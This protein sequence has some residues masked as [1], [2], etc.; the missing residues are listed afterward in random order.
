MARKQNNRFTCGDQCS[1]EDYLDHLAL[2]R[3]CGTVSILVLLMLS[4]FQYLYISYSPLGVLST[5]FLSFRD[6]LHACILSC[7]REETPPEIDINLHSLITT[8]SDHSPYFTLYISCMG[9]FIPLYYHRT[10]H[11]FYS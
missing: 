9:V 6:Y 4:V 11:F 5:H 10:W 2:H 3:L 7:R 1:D 8:L